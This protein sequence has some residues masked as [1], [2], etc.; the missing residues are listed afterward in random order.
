MFDENQIRA[1]KGTYWL[2]TFRLL[3]PR[4]SY[5][6]PVVSVKTCDDPTLSARRKRSKLAR[7]SKRTTK[8]AVAE[9]LKLAFAISDN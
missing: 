7:T 8:T 3:T 6:L 5:G 2:D 9:S 4:V 1:W